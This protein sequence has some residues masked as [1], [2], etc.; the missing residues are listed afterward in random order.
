MVQLGLMNGSE[1]VLKQTKEEV[2]AGILG[3]SDESLT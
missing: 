3:V 2:I 1:Q